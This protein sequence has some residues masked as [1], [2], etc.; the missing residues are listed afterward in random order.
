MPAIALATCLLLTQSGYSQTGSATEGVKVRR[1]QG[2]APS[3]NQSGYSQTGSA[4]KEATLAYL[5]KV[6]QT[7]KR[8]DQLLKQAKEREDFQE[9]ARLLRE[10]ARS[11]ADVSTRN[12]D[13]QVVR[14]SRE[15]I[16]L[17][18]EAADLAEEIG[19]HNDVGRAVLK[20]FILGFIDGLIGQ[21]VFLPAAIADEIRW[22][23]NLEQRCRELDR[24]AKEFD[25][26]TKLMLHELRQR[27][28]LGYD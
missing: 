11:W 17:A 28:G 1:L 3:Y 6:F 4:T 16:G 7:D 26:K 9:A 18:L 10:M 27:Y 15:G 24:K 22:A 8:Y 19:R 2:T 13:P 5:A 23:A 14:W 21:P 12:V 25:R 20:G